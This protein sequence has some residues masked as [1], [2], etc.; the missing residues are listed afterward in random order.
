MVKNMSVNNSLNTPYVIG[1]GSSYP[2][3]YGL[4]TGNGTN[5]VSSTTL[6]DGEL[7]IGTTGGA[8]SAA[9]LTAGTGISITNAA[10]SITID[11]TGASFSW[12][13]NTSSTVSMSVNT[14]Y[15]NNPASGSVTYTLPTTAAVGDVIEIIGNTGSGFSVAQNSG[16]TIRLGSVAST[17]GTGGSVASSNQYDS[18]KLVCT[19][20]NTAFRITD[21]V[22]SQLTI[23]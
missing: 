4:L 3:Q 15:I 14:G 19:A 23:S 2:T 16:Q 10:G 18:I 20:A 9:T 13:E 7:L 22:T 21:A 1:G 5:A 12:I 8:A 6:A 17:S 11:A